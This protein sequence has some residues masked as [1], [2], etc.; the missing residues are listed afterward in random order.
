[1]LSKNSNSV[2]CVT[3]NDS[4]LTHVCYN[5][6]PV[7]S[8]ATTMTGTNQYTGLT[9]VGF[10]LDDK[11][12]FAQKIAEN[13]QGKWFG[14]DFLYKNSSQTY[15]CFT[16]KVPWEGTLPEKIR[17]TCSITKVEYF[18]VKFVSNT[19]NCGDCA[20]LYS[21][22]L[23]GEQ[24]TCVMPVSACTTCNPKINCYC[25]YSPHY[26]VEGMYCSLGN[27]FCR[28]I[29]NGYEYDMIPLDWRKNASAIIIQGGDIFPSGS[30]DHC[31]QF[32]EV[33]LAT[34][35]VWNCGGPYNMSGDPFGLAY[36]GCLKGLVPNS[37]K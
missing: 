20:G 23:D 14:V 10:D 24:Y 1:M 18:S 8:L 22:K 26:I 13:V 6:Y 25:G 15:Y 5:G 2:T 3:L 4:K 27:L 16:D 35:M 21:Y 30:T 19:K 28:K 31:I 34:R 12:C 9:L 29:D 36:G 33:R 37:N 7:F 11:M 32:T 17:T